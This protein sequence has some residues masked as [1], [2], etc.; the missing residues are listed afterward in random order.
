M[1]GRIRKQFEER[2]EWFFQ[3]WNAE[4]VRDGKSGRSIPSEEAPE[5]ALVSNPDPWI[6]HPED[7]WHSF[8]DLED[9]Y[10]MLDPIKVSVITPGVPV[11]VR[12]R[13]GA[14]RPRL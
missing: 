3:T 2:Q 5:D 10:A 1:I 12:W 6:L 8:N 4:V 9:S 13:T 11:T 14:F 7:C